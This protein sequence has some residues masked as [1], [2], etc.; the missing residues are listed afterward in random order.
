MFQN[1]GDTKWSLFMLDLE[2]QGYKF[3]LEVKQYYTL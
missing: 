3:K 2:K 1:I